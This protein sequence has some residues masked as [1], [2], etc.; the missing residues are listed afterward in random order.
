MK[1]VHVALAVEA[2]PFIERWRMRQIR[3]S[4]LGSVYRDAAND[5]LLMVSGSGA[6]ATASALSAVLAQES[7]IDAVLNVGMAGCPWTEVACGEARLIHQVNDFAN[8]RTYYPDMLTR[9]SW[10][11]ASLTTYGR[12][13]RAVDD[14]QTLVDMEG[15][16]F[17]V[18][19]RAVLPA[20]RIALLKVVSDHL[21]A[22]RVAPAK[23]V[24]WITAHLEAIDAFLQAW[25]ET[26]E[27]LL[28]FPAVL[29]TQCAGLAAAWSLTVTQQHQLRTVVEG[30]FYRGRNDWEILRPEPLPVM[31]KAARNRA[32]QEL[33]DE[34]AKTL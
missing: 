9:H 7:T 12:V 26:P 10:Q 31:T 2:R 34:L 33:C 28:P 19:A 24:D 18:A 30:A 3:S 13:V 5:H 20:H 15:S 11:E 14:P 22:E 8:G 4:R 17:F 32:F 6:L 23:V 16:G 1:L 21:D 27:E 29:A 25:V